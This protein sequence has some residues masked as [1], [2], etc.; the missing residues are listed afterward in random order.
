MFTIN[1]DLP[2][3]DIRMVRKMRTPAPI[4]PILLVRSYYDFYRLSY[5]LVYVYAFVSGVSVKIEIFI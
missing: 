3:F 2:I 5:E 4:T 1:V